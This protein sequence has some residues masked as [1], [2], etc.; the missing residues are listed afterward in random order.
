MIGE[1]LWDLVVFAARR[2]AAGRQ[3][4]T[5]LSMGSVVFLCLVLALAE[6]RRGGRPGRFWSRST[7]TDGLYLGF[8]LGG[9]FSILV[10]NPL[11]RALASVLDG[12]APRMLDAVSPTLQVVLWLVLVDAVGYWVHRLLHANRFLWAF[13]SVHHS[14]EVFT[15][16]TNF[17]GHFVDLGLQSIIVFVLGLALGAPRTTLLPLS[18]FSIWVA[19]LAHSGLGWTYGPLEKLIVSPRHHRIHHSAEPR[20]HHSNFGM[21]FSL[22]DHLFG[23]AEMQAEPPRAYGIAGE[24]MPESFTRQLAYPFLSLARARGR[25]RA[26]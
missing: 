21:T 19:L 13:H 7:R 14:Q 16:L 6:W 3:G 1:E 18:L 23:T 12:W 9:V 25:A 10:S 15:P 5:I 22:W 20:H 24:R 8:Y 17:R 4:P 2:W 11:H 26:A